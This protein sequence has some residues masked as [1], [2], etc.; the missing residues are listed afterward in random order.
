MRIKDDNKKEAIFE[1]AIELLNEMGFANISM[2]KIGKKAGFSSS[3]IYVYFENKEDMLKKVYLDVKEKLRTSLSYG[4]TEALPIRRTVEQIVRN[5]FAFVMENKQY[6][7]FI[8]QFSNSPLV[9]DISEAEMDKLF[10]PFISIFESGIKEGLLKKT[11]PVLHMTYCYQ[12]VSQVAKAVLKRN[13][14]ISEEEMN[15]II[16]MSWDAIKA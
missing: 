7:L 1:A 10:Q 2:S 11:N 12:P 6:F 15:Q 16:N 13:I 4:I 9:D 8:E 14:K 5:V 3:T